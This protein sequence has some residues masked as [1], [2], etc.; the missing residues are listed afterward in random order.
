MPVGDE[1][2][3]GPSWRELAHGRPVR[4]TPWWQAQ[5]QALLTIAGVS[6]PTYV[7]HL[8]T[9][10]A[11][12]LGQT[13][14]RLGYVRLLSFRTDAAETLALRVDRLLQRGAEGLV[15]DLRGNHGGLLTEA[16]AT[17]SLFV[18]AGLV[19]ATDGIHHGR[20]EYRVAGGA[21][22]VDLALIVLVDRESA[23]AAEVVAAALEDHDRAVVVGQP[24]YGKASVQAVRLAGPVSSSVRASRAYRSRSA[25][26]GPAARALPRRRP[27]APRPPRRGARGSSPGDGDLSREIRLCPLPA[28]T[29]D[30]GASGPP[31]SRVGSVPA[32]LSSER[33]GGSNGPRVHRLLV[34]AIRRRSHSR[35]DPILP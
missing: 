25:R 15:L 9:V 35:C 24:T 32:T 13:E 1:S 3:F 4:P 11:R 26:S 23:S 12:L 21:P 30:G 22:H 18:Q 16:V 31:P 17:V 29:H 20:R 14:G 7:Y 8:P 5:R 27:G 6:T 10:R 28:G 34:R 19:V 2:V 33:E